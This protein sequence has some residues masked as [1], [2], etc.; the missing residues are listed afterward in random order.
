MKKSRK[1]IIGI[2]GA[3]G[4]I[5]GIRLLEALAKTDVETHLIISKAAGITITQETALKVSDVT[6]LA[7][8]NYNIDDIGASI[9]SGSFKTMGMVI[10]PCSVKS[11]S[12]IACG[13]TTNLISRAADVI[14]KERRKLV[15][16]LRESPLHLGHLRNMTNLC[17]MG[18][19]IAPPLPAFYP[20]PE[21]IDDIVNHNIGR[22]L[23]LFDID[24]S[25][26]ARWNGIRKA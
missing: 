6:A 13:V 11:M 17:E 5:Y 3:S 25:Y 10:M 9:S 18:A 21:T 4:A 16:G 24:N 1:L 7:D 22:I 19:I 20:Q 8:Y 14:L 15:L 23:D 12:E 26:A 2:S